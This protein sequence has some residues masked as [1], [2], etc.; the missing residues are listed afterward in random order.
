MH[1]PVAGLLMAELILDGKTHTL[2]IS[3]LRWSRFAEGD[4]IR[5]HNVV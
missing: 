2:D 1:G 3:Q 4:L 5:E